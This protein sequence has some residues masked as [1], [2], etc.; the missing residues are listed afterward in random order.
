[1]RKIRRVCMTLALAVLLAGMTACGN[2]TTNDTGNG[3]TNTESD[4]GQTDNRNDVNTTE[5]PSN[6]NVNDVTEVYPC[7]FG[8]LPFRLPT[9]A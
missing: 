5:M 2:N 1:M 9:A 8:Y 7:F 4:M 6:D 3:N